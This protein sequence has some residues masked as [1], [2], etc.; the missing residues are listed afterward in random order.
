MTVDDYLRSQDRFDAIREALL[1]HKSDWQTYLS[2]FE[3]P[4]SHLFILRDWQGFL[5]IG[6]PGSAACDGAPLE[7]SARLHQAKDKLVDAA[8]VLLHA[9]NGFFFSDDLFD[10]QAFWA[11]EDKVLWEECSPVQVYWIERQVREKIWTQTPAEEQGKQSEHPL[12][13][14]FFG[15]KGGVGRSS[16]LL[17]SAYHLMTNG[18][19][20]LVL[21]ADFES[22]GVSSTLLAE[23]LRPDY[24][25]MD[26]F[27]L[28]SLQ[29]ELTSN[30][31]ERR[32]LAERSGLERLSN[33]GGGVFV[34]PAYGHKTQDYVGKLGRLYQ[35]T[36]G[37]SYVERFT[38][39][40]CALEKEYRPDVVLI[41]SRAGVDDTSALALTQLN[42]QSLLFATHGR[43][44]WSAYQLLFS[45][46]Q[47]FAEL[48]DNGEDF[49]A[50]L[51]VVSAA[52]AP[53]S[54]TYD[55]DFLD[56][57]YRLFQE[58]LYEE[59]AEDESEGERFNFGA[60]D[61]D[62]PHFPSRVRWDDIL[63][64][65]DPIQNPAQLEEATFNKAFGEL[66]QLIDQ[67]CEDRSYSTGGE[68]EN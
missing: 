14:V 47:H 59:L 49:R 20:V 13:V 1:A 31:I 39:L 23:D 42:A 29:P 58:H 6:I 63:R 15:I 37:K 9:S 41:D 17:A 34:A 32:M 22:P 50:N 30:L 53:S 46:W 66:M 61:P 3:S 21:D 48:K 8:G 64:N 65:F 18:K 35:D 54:T 28:D 56:A 2:Q 33:N 24:G 36:S 11:T 7:L 43:A 52:L 68:H 60:D 55:R 67:W 25:L 38:T 19:T 5:H 4:F 51:H 10:A 27:A 44:T 62:A 16:A 12:R 40:L 26:W 57:S 45:H